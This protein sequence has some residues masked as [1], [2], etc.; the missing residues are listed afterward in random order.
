MSSSGTS[1][2]SASSRNSGGISQAP[3]LIR[4]PQALGQ[5]PRQVVGDAAAGD[6]RG[7]VNA[8]LLEQRP[9]RLEVAAVDLEQ[10]VRDARAEL[11]QDLLRPAAEDLEQHL[12]GER[13]AVG[14]EAGRRQADQHVALLDRRAVEDALAVDH[15]D[16]EPGEVV[17]AVG[18]EARHL[19]G[20]AAEQRD[21]AVAAGRRHPADHRRRHSRVEPAGRQVVEEEERPR[22]LDQDVVDAVVDQVLADRVV[23]A[24][25]ERDLELGAD[26]VRRRHQHRLLEALGRE[27]EHAAERALVGQHA[28]GVGRPHQLLDPGQRLVLGVDVHPRIAVRRH[29]ASCPSASASDVEHNDP[30]TTWQASGRTIRARARSG[31]GTER[32]RKRGRRRTESGT[33]GSD[34]LQTPPWSCSTSTGRRACRR[35]SGGRCSTLPGGWPDPRSRRSTPSTASTSHSRGRCRPPSRRSC[36]G[37]SPRPSSRSA[38]GR[39]ASSRRR[40]ARSSRS[41]RG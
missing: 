9:H 37:C 1:P 33:G 6:V 34:L 10:L 30:V 16:D 26:A 40:P 38:A 23:A 31:R 5:D 8:A 25:G 27:P 32:E 2:R 12:A 20:L 28:V 29:A 14:V 17:L 39:R 3:T 41:A 13:V 15:A 21:A 24:G 19:G 22:A 18:V 4:A 7:G 36:G 11:G 35:A